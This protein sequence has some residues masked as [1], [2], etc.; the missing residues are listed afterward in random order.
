MPVALAIMVADPAATPVTGTDTVVAPAAK[1]TDAGT[2]ATAGLLEL[3]LTT[4]PDEA[5]ADRFIARFCVAVP[6]MLMVA[7]EKLMA[8][9]AVVTCTGTLAVG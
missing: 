2:V 3:R 7:G 6:P 9:G 5:G 8:T 1:L 4:S